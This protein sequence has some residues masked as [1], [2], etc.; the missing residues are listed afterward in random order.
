MSTLSEFSAKVEAEVNRADGPSVDSGQEAA[1]MAGLTLRQQEF[2]SRAERLLTDIMRP[3]MQVVA[4]FFPNAN[5]GRKSD[6]GH[7]TWWFGYTERFSASVKIDLSMEHDERCENLLL[8]YELSI[9][10]SFAKYERFD[11][12]SMS[13]SAV[14]DATVADW[15]E[16]R[17]LKFVRTYLALESSD[18]DQTTSLATDP[19]CGMRIH[20]DHAAAAARHAGH[21]YFFCS[22]QCQKEFGEDPSR[23]V[24][25]VL[26]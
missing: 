20:R 9:I 26:I 12:I 25:M 5:P 21:D 3:R 19:V 10:P 2:E 23:Y 7:C 22:T 18:R 4:A 15:L 11:R 14:D 16:R 17:L 24:K 13:L 8:T 6:H 1:Y